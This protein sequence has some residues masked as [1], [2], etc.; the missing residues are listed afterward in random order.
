M[1]IQQ[2]LLTPGNDHGRTGKALN[3]EGVLIHYVGNPGS[4]AKGNRNWFETGAGGAH[5]SAHYIVGLQG[6]ILQCVPENERAAH[7]GKSFGKQWDAMAKTNNS[8]Y[9]GIEVCHPGTDGMFLPATYTE[10]VKLT[11]DIC[12][13]HGFDPR[14]Q[15]L[16]HYD[17]TGKYCPLYYV[18]NEPAW[19]KFITDV[20]AALSPSA[21]AAN[22]TPEPNNAAIIWL[23][24]SSKGLP[25]ESVAGL[26][27]NLY[28]ESG[29]RP[30][31]LQN[32]FEK[33][34]GMIDYV[35]TASVDNGT[36]AN[37]AGDG[38]GYGLA[39]WTYHTRK[40]TLLDFAKAANASIGNLNMQLDFLWKELQ[41]YTG[42]VTILKAATTVR[43]ASDAVLLMYEKPADLSAA[44]Q[45]K[46]AE[47]AQEFYDRFAEKEPAENLPGGIDLAPFEINGQ[48]FNLPRILRD[49]RN[50]VQLNALCEALEIKL[51]Y[52]ESRGM[53]VLETRQ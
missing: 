40:Q 4:T 44:V 19:A 14:K 27:G 17:V 28:A 8:K 26:M 53:A 18:E 7:A 34:L 21:P 38:A 25:P 50:Y 2:A 11:A 22:P 9:L 32:G 51:G 36:Y 42:L 30:N 46:R 45:L 6:E 24:S 12:Q 5:T 43:E 41:G 37:F 47:Y 48:V 13:R 3:P 10:L 20:I 33:S 15:V 16:R 1:T 29:L 52:D 31:N 39:Q 23:F 35:Y 49:G